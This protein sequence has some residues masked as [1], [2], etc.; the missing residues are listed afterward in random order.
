MRGET[1]FPQ[2]LISRLVAGIPPAKDTNMDLTLR[3]WEILQLM[4][5]GLTYKE[6]AKVLNISE[7]TIKYHMGQ[8]IE[9]LNVKNRE[10]AVTYALRVM[11]K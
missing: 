10:Q 3:Q 9:R 7:V 5:K 8:I 2:P 4:A 1:S 6:V 11:S